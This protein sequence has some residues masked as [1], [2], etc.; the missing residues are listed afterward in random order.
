MK[1]IYS[2][3]HELSNRLVRISIQNSIWDKIHY[4][5]S[6][7]DQ[8]WWCGVLRSSVAAVICD[9]VK[10]NITSSTCQSVLMI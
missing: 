3:H 5:T 6:N 8:D 7:N 2:E 1:D 10:D 9:E 4:L